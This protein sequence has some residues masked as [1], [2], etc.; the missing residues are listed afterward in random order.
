MNNKTYFRL[1]TKN[2][3]EEIFSMI[4][5]RQ[6]W[7]KN[8]N[9]KQWAH[10]LENH[11]LI[12]WTS[13]IENNNLYVLTDEK[14]ILGCVE[15]TFYDFDFWDNSKNL[16]LHKL[17][18]RINTHKTGSQIIEHAKRIAIENNLSKIRLICLAFNQKLNDIYHSHGF[19]HIKQVESDSYHFNLKELTL[20]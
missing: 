17:C 6:D 3:L 1:A 5:E 10:Y 2:D 13:A 18:T 14:Q 19:K 11:P 16:Y 15:I 8:H 9:I 7:F 20:L 12:E 4:K